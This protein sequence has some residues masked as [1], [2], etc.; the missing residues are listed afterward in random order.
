MSDNRPVLSDSQFAH[1]LGGSREIATG[2]QG[3]GSG[4]YV[5]RD[6]RMPVEMGG[7][8]ETVGGLADVGKVR[9]HLEQIKGKAE[10]VM[11]TGWM[12]ARAATPTE[13]A[14]V[15]QGIWQDEESKKTYLDVS[16][17]VGGRASRKSLAEGLSRGIEQKQLAIYAAGS[18]R[19]LPT[20]TEDKFGTKTPNP[21]A[22]MTLNY[23][24]KQ[25][26]ESAAR[27]KMSR[28]AKMKEKKEALAAFDTAFPRKK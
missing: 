24:N 23:L 9:E 20:N 27:R 6:P 14:N 7:S 25:N 3:K 28:G 13:S 1:L 16:D 10:K 18:G 17:R 21:A 15:H 11:P 12:K 22:E 4:Y 2:K 5:S 19:V 8:K 26:A